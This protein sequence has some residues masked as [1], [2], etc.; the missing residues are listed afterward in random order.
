VATELLNFIPFEAQKLGLVLLLSFLIGLEREEHKAD[1][2]NKGSFFG[3]VRTFPLLG[4]FGY[5]V[6]MI[7]HD[8]T[9]PIAAG[10]LIVGAFM[11]MSFRHKIMVAATH[12]LTSEISGLLTFVIGALVFEEH[13]WVASTLVVVGLFLL[14]LKSSL[15]GLATRL[16]PDE[17]LTFAKFLLLAVVIL[18]TLPDKPFTSFHINPFKTWLIVVTISGISY[19]S[20]ILQRLLGKKGG[21]F[22]AAVLGGAY[23]STLTS[24]VLAKRSQ[25]QARAS[26]FSG[27]IL[28][29]SGV[30]YV[31][32]AVILAIFGR[33][34]PTIVIPSLLVLGIVGLSGGFAWTY[35]SHQATA[36]FIEIEPKNPLE[37]S[38]ALVFALLFLAM[39]MLSATLL[40]L[41]GSAGVYL[42]AI[43]AGATDV[44]PFVLGLTQ[45]AGTGTP[46]VVA[47]TS[48][49]ISAASNNIAKGIY[50]FIF[51]RER[52]GIESLVLLAA[53]AFLGMAPAVY[54]LVT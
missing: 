39:M 50:A 53:L 6:A 1:A 20:Y 27:A 2:S 47:A 31:R 36:A 38:S 13:F 9:A 24:I 26:L 43:V 44:D 42:L 41:V 52:A 28:M 35:R 10:L 49:F 8:Q 32:L 40:A 11:A 37:L 30:M 19:A 18:P 5:S 16:P 29:A 33:S 54:F 48:V 12:G 25:G 34:M 21:V 46:A 15:E 3:G 14:E 4:A 17:I 23:S 51:S 7:S 22:A 45:S